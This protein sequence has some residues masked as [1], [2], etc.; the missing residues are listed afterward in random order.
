MNA[1]FDVQNQRLLN[2]IQTWMLLAGMIT[3]VLVLGYLLGGI[4]GV[5]WA[6]AAG[7]GMSVFGQQNRQSWVLRMLGARK[8]PE[9]R[10][11]WLYG[12]V[13]E[14]SRRAGLDYQPDIYWV[15]HQQLNAFAVGQEGWAAIAVTQGLLNHME[16]RDIINILA[17][18][19]SHLANGDLKV[20]TTAAI[21]SRVTALF[22]TVGQLLLFINLPL[23]LIGRSTISW[24]AI[25]LLL[26]APWLSGILQ[27]AISR[28]REFEA[29]LG[30]VKLTRDPLGLAQALQKLERSFRRRYVGMPLPGFQR[31]QHPLFATH[32]QTEDRVERLRSMAGNR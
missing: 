28:T 30:A 13:R 8:L 3:L 12:V 10:A 20:M 5:I 6:G 22:S 23:L 29:D 2:Q 1:N 18:E 32:P 21:V 4:T 14:L 24:L 31:G 19:I 25:V 15:P 26:L 11:A 9:E 16:R 27:T 17:H 7:I